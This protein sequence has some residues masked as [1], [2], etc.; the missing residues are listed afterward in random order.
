MGTADCMMAFSATTGDAMWISEINQSAVV[1]SP[2]VGDDGT[3]YFGALDG[4]FHAVDPKTGL[5]I[6]SFQAVVHIVI[7]SWS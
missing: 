1:A 7:Y 3:V 4:S 2:T 6:W 5:N